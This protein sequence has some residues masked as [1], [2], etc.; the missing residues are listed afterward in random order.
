MEDLESLYRLL[1]PA[2]LAY[3]RRRVGRQGDAE[4][5]L[6]ETFVIAARQFESLNAADSPKAWLF[7]VSRNLAREQARRGPRRAM[8]A[9][10]VEPVAPIEF[11]D[12]ERLDVMR[13]AIDRLPNVQRE[14]LELRLAQD[15]SYAEIAQALEIPIG[16]V[17]SRLHNA[18]AA[19][20]QTLSGKGQGKAEA[21][22]GR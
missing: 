14:V 9:I 8:L 16:T 4:G 12:D 13:V 10:S 19:L 18:V 1:G 20:R 2:L 11:E 22:H 5:L 3:L 21:F 7:G 17:R 15:L 6:Q